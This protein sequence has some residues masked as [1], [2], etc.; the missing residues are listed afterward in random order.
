V[1][2]LR[3]GVRA[4]PTVPPRPWVGGGGGPHPPPTRYDR[5]FQPGYGLR[6]S[7]RWLETEGGDGSLT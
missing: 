7:S 6:W 2:G 5:K 4:H 1:A 3:V